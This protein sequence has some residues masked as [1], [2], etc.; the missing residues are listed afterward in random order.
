MNN[1]K[2]TYSPKTIMKC[3]FMLSFEDY[4]I[5]RYEIG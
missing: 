5:I 4:F 1:D 3:S 2:D